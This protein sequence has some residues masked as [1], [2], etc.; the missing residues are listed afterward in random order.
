M[1]MVETD[2]DKVTNFCRAEKEPVKKRDLLPKNVDSS[3]LYPALV[4]GGDG[5][6]EVSHL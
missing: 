4:E 6:R 1:D 5:N 2:G 3:Y